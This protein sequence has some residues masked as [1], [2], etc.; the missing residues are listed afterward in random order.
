MGL[1]ALDLTC[2]LVWNG[3]EQNEIGDN[4]HNYTEYIADDVVVIC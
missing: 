2:V 3:I 4:E 1:S